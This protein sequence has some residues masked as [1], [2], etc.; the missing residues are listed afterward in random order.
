MA[1][2]DVGP[3]EGLDDAGKGSDV[4]PERSGKRG[5]TSHLSDLESLP[6][7]SSGELDDMSATSSE[8]DFSVLDKTREYSLGRSEASLVG[9]DFDSVGAEETEVI[10]VASSD[11]EGDDPEGDQSA[12]SYGSDDGMTNTQGGDDMRSLERLDIAAAMGP[13]LPAK[14]EKQCP[15]VHLD[16]WVGN[17]CHFNSM[18]PVF[19]AINEVSPLD[20]VGP[21]T[22]QAHNYFKVV[23]DI[24]ANRSTQMDK[25][26]KV[27]SN[28]ASD[29][30]C[31]THACGISISS[32]LVGVS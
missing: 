32:S 29:A 22:S 19:V 8:D 13:L 16:A 12:G 17:S 25:K 28:A 3:G 23:Q 2:S 10:N 14:D 4:E 31:L 21:V 24:A 18:L 20:A 11:G 1:Y 30:S 27:R 9:S 15:A 26:L 5:S 7:N 6:R